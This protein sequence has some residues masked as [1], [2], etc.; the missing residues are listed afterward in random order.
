V[1]R[2]PGTRQLRLLREKATAFNDQ[3]GVH[4]AE[5]NTRP[6]SK[7]SKLLKLT[8]KSRR[9]AN[10]LRGVVNEMVELQP[11]LRT[12]ARSLATIEKTGPGRKGWAPL[13]RFVADVARPLRT[14]AGNVKFIG[15]GFERFNLIEDDI[16]ALCILVG[17]PLV[18]MMISEPQAPDTRERSRGTAKADTRGDRSTLLE[19]NTLDREVAPIDCASFLLRHALFCFGM[20]STTKSSA[21]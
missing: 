9:G 19:T 6:L 11:H 20:S 17:P 3:P 5:K 13:T 16:V 10:H 21:S 18:T 4:R 1:G 2:L 12:H 14:A 8:A 15:E 7:P